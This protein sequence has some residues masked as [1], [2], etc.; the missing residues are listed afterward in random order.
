MSTNW[1]I[2]YIWAR[3]TSDGHAHA[4]KNGQQ[5]SM[6][7][8]SFEMREVRFVVSWKKM[9]WYMC[10]DAGMGLKGS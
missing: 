4:R 6:C 2:G 7:K 3:L 1:K 10:V 9:Q 8:I 5:G